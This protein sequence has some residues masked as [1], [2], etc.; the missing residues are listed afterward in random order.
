MPDLP[1]LTSWGQLALLALGGGL[2]IKYILPLLRN[3]RNG[4]AEW[5]GKVAQL[6]ESHTEALHELMRSNTEIARVVS[7][8]E[9]RGRNAEEAIRQVGVMH[10]ISQR[11]DGKE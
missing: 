1:V 10:E 11:V 9:R 3:G 8:I 2:A 4:D 7:E 6:L 5:R